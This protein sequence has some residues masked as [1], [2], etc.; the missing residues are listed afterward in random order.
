MTYD[1]I[2]NTAPCGFEHCRKKR[3]LKAWHVLL[4]FCGGYDYIFVCRELCPVLSRHGWGCDHRA[5]ASGQLAG[6]RMADG[7][8]FQNDIPNQETEAS[9][10]GRYTGHLGRGILQRFDLQSG[11]VGS[12]PSGNGE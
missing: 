2:R 7:S 3:K 1:Q 5:L 12:F 9:G 11:P 6:I 8:G 10:S 4:F